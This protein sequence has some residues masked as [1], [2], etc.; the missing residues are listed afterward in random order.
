MGRNECEICGMYHQPFQQSL[1]PRGFPDKWKLCC[2]CLA[3]ANDII[4]GVEARSPL[5]KKVE[6][7]IT[8]VK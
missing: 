2:I 3:I 7:F 8:L 1:F 6:K 4:R 5:F